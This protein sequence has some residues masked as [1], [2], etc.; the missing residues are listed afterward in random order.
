MHFKPILIEIDKLL[1][2]I[3]LYK[4]ESQYK[5]KLK[6]MINKLNLKIKKK[7]HF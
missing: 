4:N 6:R 5:H 1:K 3:I 2:P 7:M